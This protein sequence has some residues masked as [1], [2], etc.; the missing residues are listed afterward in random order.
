ML[1]AALAQF[2]SLPLSWVGS[3]RRPTQF[4]SAKNAPGINY[5]A[6]DV[7][8]T[9][10]MCPTEIPPG[11]DFCS[12]ECEAKYKAGLAAVAGEPA[13]TPAEPGAGD[14]NIGPLPTTDS[15]SPQQGQ[16]EVPKLSDQE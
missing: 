12:E 5:A 14:F 10:L 13:T 9:C 3:K 6:P 8:D 11:P 2:T 16:L 4:A 1:P 7:P 15:T